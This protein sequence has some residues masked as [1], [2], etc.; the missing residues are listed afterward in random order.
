MAFSFGQNYRRREIHAEYGGQQQGGISTPA[1]QPLVLLF[2]GDSG[3]QYGYRDGFVEGVYQYTGEG[4][5]GDMEMVRG[6][7]A[8]LD[9][10]LNGKDLH[11]FQYVGRGI[12]QY[13]GQMVCGGHHTRPAP[14]IDGR[15]RQ[16]IVF[17]LIPIESSNAEAAPAETRSELGALW[18]MPL[19]DLRELAAKRAPASND[20]K[21]A[22]RNVY[23]RSEAVR[24]YVLRR[25]G[26][27]CEGCGQPAPFMTA[28]G[29][30]YL[31]PHHIRRR[32]D[33][34]PDDPA[35]VAGVCPNCHRRA[36]YAGD[37]KSFGRSLRE[38]VKSKG[39]GYIMS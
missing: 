9:H 25:A 11:L 29:R 32:S 4:Q 16:A 36:H 31:E 27:H 34:G 33:G 5:R 38:T 26:D 30:P 14:D 17:E 21:V 2:S 28:E 23:E 39:D 18:S 19:S 22:K 35:W 24:V 6:N 12:V 37:A 20:P 7:R 15:S 10:A 3:E 8:I 13:V 1:G